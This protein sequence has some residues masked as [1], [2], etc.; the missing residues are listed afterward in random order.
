MALLYFFI[1]FFSSELI[2]VE[3]IL[4]KLNK[5]KT[6]S[7]TCAVLDICYVQYLFIM[8]KKLVQ[9]S[10]IGFIPVHSLEMQN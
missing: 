7:M 1:V 4:F 2:I 3:T 5:L 6:N 10:T 9:I 8:G